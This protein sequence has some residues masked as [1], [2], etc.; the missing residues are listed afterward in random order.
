[1]KTDTLQKIINNIRIEYEEELEFDQKEIEKAFTA[2][3]SS[4][5]NITIKVLSVAGGILAAI[6]L[7]GFLFIAGISDSSVSMMI[8]GIIFVTGSIIVNKLVDNLTLDTASITLYIVGVV[9]FSIGFMETSD[10]HNWLCFILIGIAM[11]TLFFSESFMLVFLGTLLFHFAII[12]YFENRNAVNLMQ[13]PILLC[14]FTLVWLTLS[15]ARIITFS[16]KANIIF[17]PLQ[18]GFFVAFI[19]ELLFI[20]ESSFLFPTRYSYLILS[21]GMGSATIIL[22]YN[23]MQSLQSVN[24][25]SRLFVYITAL[26]LVIPTIYA[27]YISGALLLIVL[28]FHYGFTS[29]F[30]IS[31]G[32]LI[33]GTSRFYYNM[34]ISLLNKSII[35]FATGLVI[36]GTWYYFTQQIK[37]DEKI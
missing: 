9:I 26:A 33:Y 11:A 23:V 24:I 10:S 6:F 7:T 22:L 18:A 31:I 2:S 17:K 5:S 36:I 30:I 25:R 37:K 21:L 15:E 34:Q 8:T 12:Y 4:F 14:G 35:L 28:S 3:D 16:R 20:T 27:P 29:Q 19:A 32:L 13:F 1:M